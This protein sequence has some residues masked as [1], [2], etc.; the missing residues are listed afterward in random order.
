VAVGAG[1]TQR[2]IDKKTVFVLGAGASCPCGY[3]SG[4]QL[5]KQIC[6]DLKERYQN[7]FLE[8]HLN[9]NQKGEVNQFIDTFERSHNPSI[10]LFIARN[11]NTK[12]VSTGKYIIAFEMFCAEKRSCFGEEAKV[13]QEMYSQPRND[14]SRE[15]NFVQR[16][17]FKGDDCYPYLYKR[18]TDGLSKPDILPNFSDD[19]ISFVTFNYDRSLEYFLYDSLYNSFKEVPEPEISKCLKK[20]KIL[21]VYGQI[22]PL[23]WQDSERGVDYCP[24]INED[25]LQK[26]ASNIKTIYE[27]EKN[28]ELND[29]KQLLEQAK[30]IFFLGFGYAKENLDILQL[31]EKIGSYAEVYGTALGLEN[32]EINGIKQNIIDRLT[33]DPNVGKNKPDVR[34][35]IENM[36]C[37]KLLKNY[38]SL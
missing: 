8:N 5:Q 35:K 2:V 27:Q 6:F 34:I 20:L 14:A 25:L 13:K 3:P 4:E 10:D 12:L 26:A 31:P 37:L 17:Y 7:Y 15:K 22:V 30:R 18:L 23:K 16:G 9:G 11:R 38:F 1:R 33:V 24:P 36:D 28:P 29:A 21:H 32:G 19:N